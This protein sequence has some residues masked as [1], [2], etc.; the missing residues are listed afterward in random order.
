MLKSKNITH[1]FLICSTWTSPH[2]PRV[3]L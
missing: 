1:Y 3:W 2:R